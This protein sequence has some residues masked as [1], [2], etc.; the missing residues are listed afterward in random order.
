MGEEEEADEI[1]RQLIGQASDSSSPMNL[2][3]SALACFDTLRLIFQKLPIADLARASCV[4]R[5]WNVVASD[6]EMVT[7]VFKAPWKLKEVIGTPSTGSFWRD[8]GI[9]KFGIS[10][11]IVK[12]DS[13]TSLAV[14]YS[15]Q[16]SIYFITA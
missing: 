2:N 6:K 4:C 8:N 16:V 5:S 15:V 1:H 13:V 11:R 12:G 9:G 7:S 10:H 14:K 3:F